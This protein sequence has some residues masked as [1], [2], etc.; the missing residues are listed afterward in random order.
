M[1]YPDQ[2]LL[3][4]QACGATLQKLSDEQAQRVAEAPYNYIGFCGACKRA[5]AHIQEGFG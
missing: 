4:C 3:E 1:M 5:G 2:H